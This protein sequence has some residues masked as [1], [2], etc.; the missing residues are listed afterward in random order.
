MNLFVCLFLFVYLNFHVIY[1]SGNIYSQKRD[2]LLI[3]VYIYVYIY[4]YIHIYIHIL[5]THLVFGYIYCHF[6]RWHESSNKQTKINKQKDSNKKVI[7]SWKISRF[8]KALPEAVVRRCSSKEVF[9][10]IS[11]YPQENICVGVSFSC[12]GQFELSQSLKSGWLSEYCLRYHMQHK[13]EL[14]AH[15][16]HFTLKCLWFSFQISNCSSWL[17]SNWLAKFHNPILIL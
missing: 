11:Q 9:L 17:R 7:R 4:I 12:I 15:F 13:F 6:C 3:Y 1:K 8:S 5:T 2:V 14:P 10:K 16:V